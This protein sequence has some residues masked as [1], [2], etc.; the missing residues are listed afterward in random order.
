MPRSRAATGSVVLG[1]LLAASGAMGCDALESLL[2]E[3]LEPPTRTVGGVSSDVAAIVGTFA[4]GPL[5]RAFLL[6]SWPEFL[7]YY[8]GLDSSHEA[9]FHVKA[10]FDN[11]GQRLWVTRVGDAT[12]PSLIGSPVAETGMYALEQADGFNVLLLPELFSEPQAGSRDPWV[13]QAVGYATSHS[14]LFILDPPAEVGTASEAL[15][16]AGG[17]G[18]LRT[19]FAVTYFGRIGVPDPASS[20]GQRSIGASGAVAGAYARNDAQAGVWQSPAG[21]GLPLVGVSAVDP[22]TSTEA[23]NLNTGGVNP[24]L[25]LPSGGIGLWGARTLSTDPLFRYVSVQRLTLH[26]EASIREA[27]GWTTGSPSGQALWTQA[28]SDAQG[29]LQQ[30]YQ[31]GA[32][33]GIRPRDA[34]FAN[35]NSTTH[36]TADIAARRLNVEVGFAPLK[37]AEFVVRIMTILH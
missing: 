13:S 20:G 7:L 25:P 26:V 22:L 5:D 3:D 29:V 23:G 11:G 15:A 17:P 28:E 31:S 18:V 12:A 37:P 32:F 21:A 30:Y 33:Q 35:S 8:G 10:F 34:Y 6:L 2:P 9:S 4:A 24:I 36:S 14:A 19:P 27:L 16:W 1:A